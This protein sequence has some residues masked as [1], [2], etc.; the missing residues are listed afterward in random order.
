MVWWE[1]PI[2]LTSD[3]PKPSKLRYPCWPEE[4]QRTASDALSHW[5]VW[6]FGESL[7]DGWFVKQLLSSSDPHLETLFWR[8]FWNTI[9]KYILHYMAHVSGTLSDILFG[10]YT[11]TFH[12]T[13]YLASFLTYFLAYIPTFF[14]AFYPASILASFRHSFWHS[15]WH[16]V[17]HSFWHLSGSYS[18]IL[19]LKL[20]VEVR[21]Y[22]LRA[23]ARGWGLAV[24]SE[25]WRS[26][27]RSGSAHWDLELV[28]WG[29]AVP[30]DI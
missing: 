4:C 1:V 6:G 10:I 7:D 24:L 2:Q 16:L 9:W 3:G 13:F 20:A 14:L 30:T 22:P 25:I 18:D 12:L 23:G 5:N 26:R 15:F 11:L 19:S 28:V 29:L 21:Q 17:W 8:S 27:L